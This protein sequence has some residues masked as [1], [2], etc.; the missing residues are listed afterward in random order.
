MTPRPRYGAFNRLLESVDEAGL[1][2]RYEYNGL[3]QQIREHR[4]RQGYP[5]QL[6]RR[7]PPAA[8]GR[9]WPMPPPS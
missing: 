1:S 9:P 8:G 5:P 2:T 3:G 6:G 4:A 7:R